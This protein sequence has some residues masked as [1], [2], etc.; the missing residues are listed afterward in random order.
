MICVPI[1]D[2]QGENK[3]E[4]HVKTQ[5]E[6]RMVG[7][8]TKYCQQPPGAGEKHKKD[9]SSEPLE[10]TNPVDNLILDF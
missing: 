10:G 9:S 5:A 1:R 4:S 2:R 3:G 7:L 6:I 8:Q